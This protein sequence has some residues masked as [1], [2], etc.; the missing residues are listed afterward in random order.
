VS[1]AASIESYY[2]SSF[3]AAHTST[4]TSMEMAAAAVLDKPECMHSIQ[5]DNNKSLAFVMEKQQLKH[6]VLYSIS[7]V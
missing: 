6:H 1:D 7:A 2:H 4:L 5:L 3:K